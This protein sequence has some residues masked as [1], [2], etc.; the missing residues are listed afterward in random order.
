MWA[1]ENFIVA[2][3]DSNVNG[4]LVEE[5]FQA[6]L[7]HVVNFIRAKKTS[8]LDCECVLLN[9]SGEY[10]ALTQLMK[11]M[12]LCMHIYYTYRVCQLQFPTFLQH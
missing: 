9:S 1:L 10:S 6:Y 11:T 3:S 12:D 5:L 4:W 8:K 7:R 2:L